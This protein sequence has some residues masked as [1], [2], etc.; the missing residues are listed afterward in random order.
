MPC[1]SIFLNL[2]RTGGESVYHFR[3][4]PIKL[5]TKEGV[6]TAIGGHPRFQSIGSKNRIFLYKH[7]REA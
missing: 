5:H 3:L 4:P 2:S 1:K 6:H 7:N